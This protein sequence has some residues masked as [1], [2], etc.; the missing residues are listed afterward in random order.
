MP[1]PPPRPDAARDVALPLRIVWAAVL[2][3]AAAALGTM[4]WLAL[5]RTVPAPLA[6]RA[7][8]AFYVV[9]L[10]GVVGT[11]GAFA[12]VH[13]MERRLGRAGSAAEAE[14]TVRLHTVAAL[15]AAEVPALAGALA[16]FLTGDLLALAFGAPLF[17]FAAFLW[18][19]DDR[20]GAWLGARHR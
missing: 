7:E 16:A 10:I 14:R 3:G 20:V 17:A 13:R 5:A 18:P 12:L 6:D 4:G 15:A 9:A 19:S 8:G 11:A 2:G 1:A